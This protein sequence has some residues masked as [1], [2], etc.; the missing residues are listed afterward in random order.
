MVSWN[1]L[2]K[3]QTAVWRGVN[4]EKKKK[5]PEMAPWNWT[6]MTMTTIANFGW[7]SWENSHFDPLEGKSRGKIRWN[8]INILLD[9]R[10]GMGRR[11]GGGGQPEWKCC[12][13][14]TLTQMVVAEKWG[15]GPKRKTKKRH[16]TKTKVFLFWEIEYLLLVAALVKDSQ[17]ET[18]QLRQRTKRRVRKETS[19]ARKKGNKTGKLHSRRFFGVFHGGKVFPSGHSFPFTGFLFFMKME[20]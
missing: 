3:R 10:N 15:E 11:G 20:M 7:W 18:Q 16:K 13:T 12:K 1:K 4:E 6:T 9:L 19:F 2:L 14:F 8:K 5:N 17:I